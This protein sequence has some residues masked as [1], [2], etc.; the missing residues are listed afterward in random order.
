M[1]Y[2]LLNKAQF[3]LEVASFI[4]S[5]SFLNKLQDSSEDLINTITCI[6]KQLDIYIEETKNE[7]SKPSLSSGPL[8]VLQPNQIWPYMLLHL[9]KEINIWRDG[10]LT[11]FGKFYSTIKDW[12]HDYQYLIILLLFMYGFPF[13]MNQIKGESSNKE[14]LSTLENA[15]NLVCCITTLIDVEFGEPWKAF[16]IEVDENLKNF[17]Y[18]WD[19]IKDGIRNYT[20]WVLFK[21]VMRK[22]LINFKEYDTI[23]NKIKFKKTRGRYFATILKSI[24]QYNFPEDSEANLPFDK[25]DWSWLKYLSHDHF[26]QN[27]KETLTLWDSVYKIAINL[28]EKSKQDYIGIA[29]SNADFILK[30]K[31]KELQINLS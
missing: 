9:W 16:E 31:I 22:K 2:F 24:L 29:F 21:T 7:N 4:N 8:L 27:L 18:L 19:L 30:T 14:P 1:I 15:I 26:I 6:A 12:K 3:E 25:I 11:Y 10:E 17:T 20:E 28:S 5:D 23:F 13:D